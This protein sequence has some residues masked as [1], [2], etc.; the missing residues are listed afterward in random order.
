MSFQTFVDIKESI[1]KYGKNNIV[2]IKYDPSKDKTASSKGPK[3]PCLWYS[4]VFRKA[5]DTTCRLNIKT[6]EIYLPS[7]ARNQSEDSIASN[8]NCKIRVQMFKVPK[9]R[10]N[11]AENFI[12]P[13]SNKSYDREAMARLSETVW[14]N[15]QDFI[16]ILDA[17]DC[18]IREQFRKFKEEFK[19]PK[20]AKFDQ[21][22]INTIK[23]TGFDDG[24]RKQDFGDNPHYRLTLQVD[25]ETGHLGYKGL[26]TKQVFGPVIFDLSKK[27]KNGEYCQAY[28]GD[29]TVLTNT[30][31]ASFV[32]PGSLVIMM[33]RLESLVVHQT[34]ISCPL[35]ITKMMTRANLHKR[36]SQEIVHSDVMSLTSFIDEDERTE[37]SITA[38]QSEDSSD[39]ES[40]GDSNE[41]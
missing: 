19:N 24:E 20:Y 7:G 9:E 37:V 15:N 31:V 38:V 35:F 8:G 6:P 5:D 4:L 23:L 11:V 2:A 12:R 40:I 41:F 16:E 26:E 33:L 39:P 34:G 27:P 17:L 32:T 14:H 1:A 3:R 10:I 22:D 13:G 28:A 18:S 30:N 29:N 25:K 36:G 21:E